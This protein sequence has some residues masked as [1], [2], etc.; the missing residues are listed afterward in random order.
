M[1]DAVRAGSGEETFAARTQ[2]LLVEQLPAESVGETADPDIPVAATVV[3]ARDADAG[4][5]VLLIERPD[6]GSFAGAWVFPGGKVEDADA[7]GL[8]SPP[9]EQDVARVAGVR[10]TWEETSLV[11]DAA[12]LVLL[13][14]WDPPAGVP[15][16]IRT[17]FLVGRAPAQTLVLQP[18]EAVSF[19]W[20]RPADVLAAH[21]RGELTLYP[22][23]WV[24]LHG[25]AGHPDVDTLLAQVRL[26][27]IGEFATRVRR[28]EGGAVFSWPDDAEYDDAGA[29]A[30]TARHRLEA[31]ALP[32]VYMR[33]P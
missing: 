10:E 27:G 2:R 31:G 22:P 8:P 6:R 7:A 28:G 17:W 24:T 19:Q 29:G 32:W 16:R 26:G 1:D 18:D 23:T 5:E 13:S 14:R 30:S 25:L 4:P 3:L 11:I 12:D 15:L 21:A 33:H 9:A 20:S